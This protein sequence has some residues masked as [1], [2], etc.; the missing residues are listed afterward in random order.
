MPSTQ[1][2]R[3][4]RMEGKW[5]LRAPPNRQPSGSS[6]RSRLRAT[7]AS[8]APKRERCRLQLMSSLRRARP[9]LSA[10]IKS[11][12]KSSNTTGTACHVGSCSGKQSDIKSAPRGSRLRAK[13]AERCTAVSK[14]PSTES[15]AYHAGS[16]RDGRTRAIRRPPACSAGAGGG[17][18]RTQR[19]A[20]RA[21]QPAS[22]S[23]P[24]R[25]FPWPPRDP[26]PGARSPA[27][28]WARP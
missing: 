1:C 12:I 15:A 20:L 11:H 4:H 24:R 18:G 3:E 23:C 22:R 10:G 8:K 26:A 21:L 14:Q 16:Q 2:S 6:W 25:H 17:F 28:A 19:K 5:S 9:A 27:R 7:N 13:H